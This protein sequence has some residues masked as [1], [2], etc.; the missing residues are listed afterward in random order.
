MRQMAHISTF[1][2]KRQPQNALARLPWAIW[3]EHFRHSDLER[4]T[5]MEKFC[6]L[7]LSKL[8]EYQAQENLDPSPM[9]R[10]QIETR[11]ASHSSHTSE[12]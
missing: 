11:H 7:L 12:S 4:Q 10:E 8:A 5:F 1:R 9:I 2:L 3:P 6:V